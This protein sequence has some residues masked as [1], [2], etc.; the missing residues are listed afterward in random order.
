VAC[1]VLLISTIAL[2]L[3]A[4]SLWNGTQAAPTPAP[5]ATETTPSND[6]TVQGL[7]IDVTSSLALDDFA[8]TE[9]GSSYAFL[10]ATATYNG[11]GD[12]ATVFYD[13]T[14]YAEDG[15]ILDRTPASLYMLPGQTSML[16]AIFSQDISDVARFAIEQTYD[17]RDAPVLTGELVVD[18][19]DVS[20]G[21]RVDASL[22]SALS[23]T[24]EYTDLYLVAYTEGEIYGVCTDFV[25]IAA[26]ASFESYCYL[27]AAWN[28][29]LIDVEGD[30]PDDVEVKVYASYDLP[31]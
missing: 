3:T 4:L 29:T 2:G 21:G 28:E 23:A 5:T 8:L 19:A 17:E 15:T 24:A 31:W 25:D 11:T 10:Y 1:A 16:E 12:A 22:T 30:V 26:G 27:E 7:P 6:R 13:V 18:A 9:L 14:A 20:D